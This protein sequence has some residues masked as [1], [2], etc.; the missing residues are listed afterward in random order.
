MLAT[1]RIFDSKGYRK[2]KLGMGSAGKRTLRAWA[3]KCGPNGSSLRLIGAEMEAW[4][5]N[6]DSWVH[7]PEAGGSVAAMVFCAGGMVVVMV[8]TMGDGWIR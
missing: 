2:A 1:E 5:T 4:E 3:R 8:V 7:S 6:A